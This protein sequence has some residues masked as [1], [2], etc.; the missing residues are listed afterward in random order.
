MVARSE[1]NTTISFWD[2]GILA[3]VRLDLGIWFLIPLLLISSSEH[4]HLILNNKWHLGILCSIYY[5]VRT[6]IF[7]TL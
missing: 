3:A 1:S 5:L 2:L 7:A 6:S 4:N